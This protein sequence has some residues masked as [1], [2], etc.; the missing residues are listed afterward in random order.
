VIA[1]LAKFIDW[2]VLQMAYATVVGLRHAP[3]PEWKLEEALDFLNGP[4]FIPAATD[5]ARIGFDGPRDFTFPTPRPCRVEDNN[6]VYGRLYRCAERWQERPVIVL[7]DGYPSVGYHTAFP[8]LARRVNCAVLTVPRV[9]MRCPQP[10]VW[11]RTREALQALR[12]PQEAMDTTRLNLILSTPVIPKE[13][14]LLIEG[15]HD[16]FAGRPPIEELWQKWQQPEIWRLF[17]GHV[18][19]Q[20]VLGLMGRVLGWLAPRLEAGRR[21]HA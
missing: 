19:A 13:H 1:P 21:K 18:S 14:I 6:I 2:S 15:I 4:D 17:H 10:V 12:P 3:R 7:L 16:L 8:F 5:P 9:G 11:R 20:F